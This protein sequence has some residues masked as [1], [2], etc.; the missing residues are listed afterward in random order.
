MTK[1][2]AWLDGRKTYILNAIYIAYA[3]LA[4]YNVV[5]SIDETTA[6]LVVIIGNAMTF[7]SALTKGFTDYT[8]GP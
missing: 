7:R 3:I 6:A 5:P 1:V 4:F 8:K 2:L